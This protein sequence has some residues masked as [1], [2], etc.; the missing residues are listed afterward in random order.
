M[1]SSPL[2]KR[3]FFFFFFFSLP[4]SVLLPQLFC[5]V[6]LSW[7][8]SSCISVC[9]TVPCGNSKS[10]ASTC[11]NRTGRDNLQTYQSSL[12]RARKLRSHGVGPPQ[13][14]TTAVF[15]ARHAHLFAGADQ[16]QTLL[17]RTRHLSQ[18][19]ASIAEEHHSDARREGGEDSRR[20][21]STR[22]AALDHLL[23]LCKCLNVRL[24]LR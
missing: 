20:G 11:A 19:I 22:V 7:A 2:L 14:S 1:S 16:A 17:K 12:N 4:L 18:S 23:K 10:K 13:G 9:S 21:D 5:R 6:L 24:R 15:H 8:E 3:V